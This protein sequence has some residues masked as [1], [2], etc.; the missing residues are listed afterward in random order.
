MPTWQGAEFLDAVLTSLSRQAYGGDWELLVV[1]SGSKDETL[2]IIARHQK[3]FPV[4][5]A[6]RSIHN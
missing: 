6:L 5:F 4:P 1:D 2:E 3:D